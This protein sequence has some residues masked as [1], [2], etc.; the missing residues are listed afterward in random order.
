MKIK[1]KWCRNVPHLPPPRPPLV[2]TVVAISNG[3]SRLDETV[4]EPWGQRERAAG[5]NT[6]TQL[7][8]HSPAFQGSMPSYPIKGITQAESQTRRIYAGQITHRR[9]R[10]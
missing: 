7:A 2:N 1:M 8:S 4:E 10:S 5:T 9:R 6:V 3:V